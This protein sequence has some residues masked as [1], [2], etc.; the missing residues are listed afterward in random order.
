MT[1]ALQVQILEGSVAQKLAEE[2]AASEVS[3]SASAASSAAVAS[4]SAPASGSVPHTTAIGKWLD[5][6]P[7]KNDAEHERQELLYLCAPYSCD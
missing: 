4:A 6:I 7:S 5:L 3:A 1:A 2:R